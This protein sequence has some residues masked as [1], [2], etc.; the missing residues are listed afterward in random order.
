MTAVGLEVLLEGL[1]PEVAYSGE[2]G[3]S[4]SSL[5]KIVRQYHTQAGGRDGESNANRPDTDGGGAI[6]HTLSEAE[7]IAARWAWDWLRGCRQILVNGDSRW[8]R[9]EWSEVLALPEDPEENGPIPPASEEP[10]QQ[11][12]SGAASRRKK[13]AKATKNKAAL[14]KRPRIYP[15]EDLLWQTLAHHGVDYKRIPVL[16][17]K[18]LVGIASVRGEGILQSDLRRLVDQDKRSLPKRTDSLAKKGYIQKRTVVANRMKT[19]KLWLTDFAP[20]VL[21]DEK[22]GL[23]MSTEALTKNLEPV[24]WH[25]R[26]TGDNVDVETHA[27]TILAIVKAW[28]VIRYCDLRSKM[29]VGGKSSQMKTLAKCSQRFVDMGVLKYAAA[30]LPGSRKVFKDCLKYIRDPRFEEWEKFLATGKRTS[31]YSDASRHRQ[32]KGNAL[33]LYGQPEQEGEEHGGGRNLAIRIFPGWTPEKPLSQNVFEVVKSAGPNGAS[34]PQVSV[35]T[36]GYSFRRYMA[37]HLARLAETQQPEHLKKFQVVSQ[38]VRSG[39]TSAY[40]FSVP[41]VEET[42]GVENAYGF[43]DIQAKSFP[44]GKDLS[45]SDQCDIARRNFPLA[46]RRGRGVPLPGGQFQHFGSGW[47]STTQTPAP[48]TPNE[49]ATEEVQLAHTRKRSLDQM[50][51]SDVNDTGLP[52]EAARPP[53]AG[54]PGAFTGAPGSLHPNGAEVTA[55]MKSAVV[56]IRSE[57]IRDPDF[58]KTTAPP[59]PEPGPANGGTDPEIQRVASTSEPPATVVPTAPLPSVEESAEGSVAARGGSTRGRGRGR[60]RGGRGRGGA[61]GAKAWKCE[62]CGGTW[63]NDVGLKYH[64]TK[65]QIPCNPNFDPAAAFLA[66]ARKRRRMSPPPPVRSV[67]HTDGE[68]GEESVR[69]RRTR[70]TQERGSATPMVQRTLVRSGVRSQPDP[71]R[72]FRGFVLEEPDS[73][74]SPR[75]P[76]RN[77]VPVQPP[78]ASVAAEGVQPVV[79]ANGWVSTPIPHFRQHG[80][81]WVGSQTVAMSPRKEIDVD[82]DSQLADD[83]VVNPDWVSEQLVPSTSAT[84]SQEPTEDLPY[85]PSMYPDHGMATMV[86]PFSRV[87]ADRNGS[88][89]ENINMS[90][91]PEVPRAPSETPGQSNEIIYSY[92]TIPDENERADDVFDSSRSTSISRH[93]SPAPRFSKSFQPSAA[94]DR[95][96]SEPKR[97]TAQALDIIIYL[98]NNNYGVFPGDKALFYALTKVFLEKFRGEPPPTWKNFHSAIKTLEVRKLATIHTHMLRTER[99]KLQTCA[100]LI[101]NDVD[102]AGGIPMAMKQKMRDAYPSVYIP[103][104][105]SPSSEELAQLQELDEKP[106]SSRRAGLGRDAAKS[107]DGAVIPNRNGQKFRSRRKIDEVEIF[108]AP[109]YTQGLYRPPDKEDDEDDGYENVDAMLMETP[110]RETSPNFATQHVPVEPTSRRP[111][112]RSR[113]EE[114]TFAIDPALMDPSQNPGAVLVGSEYSLAGFGAN[115]SGLSGNGVATEPPGTSDDVLEPQS[116]LEAIKTYRLLPTKHGKRKLDDD[117]GFGPRKLFKLSSQRGRVRNPGLSSLP[118]SFYKYEPKRGIPSKQVRFLPP[119]TRLEEEVE[120]REGEDFIKRLNVEHPFGRAGDYQ[121]PS[122]VVF[123]PPAILKHCSP[124]TWRARDLKTFEEGTSFTMQGWMPARAQLL[125]ENLPTSA[126]E[127]ARR[128]AGQPWKM[129][130]WL[131]QDWG[132]FFAS[133]QRCK[134]WELSQAGTEVLVYG[135]SIAPEYIFINVSPSEAKVDMRPVNLRWSEDRQF[136]LDTLPYEVLETDDDD[137]VLFPSDAPRRPIYRMARKTLADTRPLKRQRIAHVTEKNMGMIKG[138]KLKLRSIKFGRELTSY[139]LSA[140]D[141][142]RNPSAE[143]ETD[144]NSENVRLTAFVVVT[145][146]LGGVDRVV[147]WGLMLRLFPDSTISQLRHLWGSLKKDRQSTIANLTAKF[148]KAFLKAYADNELPPID[149]NNVLAYDWKTLITWAT[150]LDGEPQ[151][152]MPATR[153]QLDKEYILDGCKYENREWR[154]SYY[155]IQRSVF[156]KF[157]DASSEALALPADNVVAAPTHSP[158]MVVALSWTRSLCVTPIDTY[159]T[160]LVIARRENLYPHLPKSEVTQLILQGI[161]QLQ[162]EGVISRSTSACSNGR[163]WRFNNRVP[164][165]LDKVAQ[166]DK[167]YKAVQFKREL[168]EAFRTGGKKRVTYVTND[169]MMLALINLQAAGRVRVETTGQ[170]HVPMGH[171]PGNY[172]TR[173]YTK[174][175]LHFRLDMIP[176]DS[177]LYD[178]DP[179][180]VAVHQRFLSVA[181]PAQGPLGAIPVWCDVFGKVDN[182]RWIK[183]SSAVALTLASRGAMSAEEL[184]K[185]LK[186]TLMLFEAELILEWGVKTGVFETQLEGMALAAKEWWWMSWTLQKERFETATAT[187]KPRKLLPSAR[188]RTEEDADADA[189][190][191][192]LD[193]RDGR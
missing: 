172:E 121:E 4:V 20:A 164:D 65:A 85:G 29:G 23:D 145:T 14:A 140:E 113:A 50:D 149:F 139:P 112:R 47:R 35:A 163:R 88:Q 175:Y 45:L 68:G 99:G 81:T 27:R 42:D 110:E 82:L 156:N 111:R 64:Q 177:Y 56:V 22:A 118:D 185:A 76:E 153:S 154:E 30:G 101:R 7:M 87:S 75:S 19:S 94:Y 190:I 66:P 157:Q 117:Q 146:L 49:V 133:V 74:D 168:D 167:L 69:T 57:R 72:L 155:H 187:G 11:P 62:K 116:I 171:E 173:K 5:L 141:F 18:C 26:W 136:D 162:K 55:Q 28:G 166:F 2:K 183:Y 58:L 17:W 131:D 189:D 182:D 174:K 159:P 179:E 43:G 178:D 176:T 105:F 24:T 134:T 144:W 191:G 59:L 138:N 80:S 25:S 71:E 16:E 151:D 86:Q 186:P 106:D 161:E 188:K 6:E 8:N 98:L 44:E 3:M 34:N 1:I 77:Y 37:S 130:S 96:A 13:T 192:G 137:D 12:K 148:R 150:K 95:I 128:N 142:L 60:G 115:E 48:G 70:R 103:P 21:E 53:L 97:R 91:I 132:R 40:M 39:K 63:K 109:Y 170:P 73:N 147:D 184:V 31:Q 123:E 92:P 169:G 78:A 158:E 38:L 125:L 32:P 135:G 90:V 165:L 51:S 89:H 120:G 126:E 93:P 33:A 181:P 193:R 129:D 46:G 180:L 61:A 10:E 143:D 107:A 152:N 102:P 9:L 104:A 119:N 100:L 127:M 36:V 79:D 83:A 54:P 160:E 67:S 41:D 108:N 124:G 84:V 114:D 52:Q 122:R 15:S